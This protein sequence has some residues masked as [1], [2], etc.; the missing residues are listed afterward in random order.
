MDWSSLMSAAGP[1]RLS[2]CLADPGSV[3]GGLGVA[4]DDR[5]WQ[6]RLE[7]EARRQVVGSIKA[8]TTTGSEPGSTGVVM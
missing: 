4:D 2:N 6:G 5:L 8:D 1:H 7:I 3:N